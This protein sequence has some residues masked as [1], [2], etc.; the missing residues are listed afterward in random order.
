MWWHACFS[1]RY[2]RWLWGIFTELSI[3]DAHCQSPYSR[4]VISR[5]PLSLGHGNPPVPGLDHRLRL[6]YSEAG[7][8]YCIWRQLGHFFP[9]QH[10]QHCMSVPS[11]KD[12]QEQLEP[13]E[14]GVA[15][16]SSLSLEVRPHLNTISICFIYT[17]S[18]HGLKITLHVIFNHLEHKRNF[19][20][21]KF[22]TVVSYSL[23]KV[24]GHSGFQIH[25]AVTDA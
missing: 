11:H 3:T 18:I 7:L 24:W 8:P 12:W 16:F 6:T 17:L 20:N 23:K 19:C 14:F 1:I 22:P 15:D 10:S 2:Q 5:K 9:K 4:S 25:K 21:V 13:E